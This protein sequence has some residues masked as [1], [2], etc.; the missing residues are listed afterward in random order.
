MAIVL[1][2]V[3]F[4]KLSLDPWRQAVDLATILAV[5]VSILIGILLTKIKK[6]IL[7]IAVFACVAF[8]LY[9]NL[10]A[11]LDN[12]NAIQKVDKQ[13]IEFINTLDEDN[14]SCNASV[15]Y[16]VYDRFTDKDWVNN[17]GKLFIMRSK[18]MTPGS[19]SNN[20]WYRNHGIELDSRYEFVKSFESDSITIKIFKR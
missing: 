19:E 6:P 17:D 14:Y 12:N 2:V 4:T 13:A 15:A 3:T 16:W 7:Y 5:S 18:S 11:W 1:A 8:G 10:P 9:H 20:T